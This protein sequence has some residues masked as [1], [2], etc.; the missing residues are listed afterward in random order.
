M[1]TLRYYKRGGVTV[2]SCECG[3]HYGAVPSRLCPHS[4]LLSDICDVHR[5]HVRTAL[6]VAGVALSAKFNFAILTP[7]PLVGY[8]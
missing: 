3:Q 2:F 7:N 8:S 5:E 1:H 4:G 6:A